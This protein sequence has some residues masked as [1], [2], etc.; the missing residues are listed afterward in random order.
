MPYGGSGSPGVRYGGGARPVL[1]PWSMAD[2]REATGDGCADDGELPQGTASST[3]LEGGGASGWGRGRGKENYRGGHE[4]FA[5]ELVGETVLFAYV[6][7]YH[8]KEFLQG[9]IDFCADMIS[10]I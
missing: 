10:L 8:P 9:R 5:G 6:S 4:G 1:A 3:S 7:V 2:V